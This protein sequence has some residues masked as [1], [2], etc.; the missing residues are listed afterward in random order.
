MVSVGDA[1]IA[2]DADGSSSPVASFARPKSSTF[3]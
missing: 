2:A 1:V 3:T